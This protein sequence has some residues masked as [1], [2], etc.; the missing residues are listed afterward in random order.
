MDKALL[1]AHFEFPMHLAESHSVQGTL[2]SLR[3]E[4][5]NLILEP[6]GMV[7]AK[8]GTLHSLQFLMDLG[9]E[10]ATGWVQLVYSDLKIEVLN[11]DHVNDGGRL[12]FKTFLANALKVKNDNIKEPFRRG[13]VSKERVHTKSIFSYWWKSLSTGLKDNIGM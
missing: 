12:R 5:L 7:R 11:E 1:T 2:E 8:S 10:N 4:D 9:A 6:V 3:A 13:E